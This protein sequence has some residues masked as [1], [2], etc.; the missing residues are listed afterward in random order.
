MLKSS[1]IKRSVDKDTGLRPLFFRELPFGARQQNNP[2]FH[3]LGAVLPNRV[4][5]TALLPLKSRI[6]LDISRERRLTN[7]SGTAGKQNS[8]LC[9]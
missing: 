4:S 7:K 1:A 8:S 6:L 9:A 3:H 5:K 2:F